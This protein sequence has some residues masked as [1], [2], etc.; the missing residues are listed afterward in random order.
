MMIAIADVL[1]PE[2]VARVR[3]IID[4]AEWVDGN[5]TSGAQSAQLLNEAASEAVFS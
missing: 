5:V 1:N 4:A 3:A 2:Q